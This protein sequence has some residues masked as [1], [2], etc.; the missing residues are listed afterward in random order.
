MVCSERWELRKVGNLDAVV[1]KLVVCSQWPPRDVAGCC[2]GV[3][4]TGS[5]GGRT[6]VG[7]DDVLLHALLIDHDEGE[8]SKGCGRHPGGS[9]I[10]H[11]MP[12]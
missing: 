12:F 8:D 9:V 7:V 2:G 1:D 10:E 11:D 5:R 4:E 6:V 3:T